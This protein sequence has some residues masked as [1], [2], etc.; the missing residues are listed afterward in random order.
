[1]ICH[2]HPAVADDGIGAVRTIC[3]LASADLLDS[4]VAQAIRLDPETQ[5]EFTLADSLLAAPLTQLGERFEY[6]GYVEPA[7]LF[8]R[9]ATA[10]SYVRLADS[11]AQR[12][13]RLYDDALRLF[14]AGSYVRAEVSCKQALNV[15][16]SI[17]SPRVLDA[18]I[19][20][21]S[22]L[23]GEARG[24]ESQKYY[25]LAIDYCDEHYGPDS[26]QMGRALGGIANGYYS[27]GRYADA[28]PL[29]RRIIEIFT[30]TLGANSNAVAAARINLGLVYGDL[31]RFDRATAELEQALD[32]LQH[33]DP[34][35][36]P[37]IANAL[38]NLGILEARQGRPESAIDHLSQA[39]DIQRRV[40]GRSN[41]WTLT[42]ATQ[43]TTIYMRLGELSKAAIY[44]EEA[45]RLIDSTMG[46]HNAYAAYRRLSLAW[47]R[48]AQRRYDES[49]TLCREAV[50]TYEEL[51]GRGNRSTAEALE[52]LARI[53]RHDEQFDSA[54]VIAARAL[55]MRL[56]VL[57]EQILP[58]AER[59]AL[60]HSALTRN[61]LNGLVASV[62][63]AS[64]SDVTANAIDLILT[65]KGC[66][67]DAMLARHQFFSQSFDSIGQRLWR[68]Y[69]SAIRRQ[70]QLFVAG[71]TSPGD[72]AYHAALDSLWSEVTER[73]AALGRHFGQNEALYRVQIV[74]HR[75]LA[76]C[77]PPKTC[78]VEFIDYESQDPAVFMAQQQRYAAVVLTPD[79]RARVYSLGPA[80]E[81]DSLVEAYQ[82]HLKSIA[83]SGRMPGR[84]QKSEYAMIARA[85]Y[86]RL[87]KPIAPIV[88]SYEQVFVAPDGQLNRL[89]F[90]T[91]IEDDGHYL[92]EKYILQ[93]L[94]AGRDLLRLREQVTPGRGLIAIAD[95]DFSAPVANPS[96]ADGG[97]MTQRGGGAH[98]LRGVS[99]CAD[100]SDYDLYP[101]PG[102]R[103]EI[104]QVDSLWRLEYGEPC[105]DREGAAAT[106]EFLKS[107]APGKRAA[108]LA[109]H[110]YF[111][112]TTCQSD[113][114]TDYSTA[115]DQVV[116]L[117]NPLLKSGLF[118][119]GCAVPAE[120]RDTTSHEDGVLTAAEIS[121][122]NLEG[123]QFVVLSACE[124][125]KGELYNG[126]GVYGLR[127]AFHVAGV[128]TVISA[129]WSIA[130]QFTAPMM[131]TI[132]EHSDESL[133]VR[134]RR[135]Q[136]NWINRL[137]AH[138]LSDHPFTWGAFIA[139][140]DWR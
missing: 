134:L 80:E 15:W 49:E 118:L 48:F 83:E 59:D 109:T 128:R 130:D 21:G 88:E 91:L 4:A 139:E 28:E 44:E 111:L 104:A 126:E 96:Y 67:S 136:L 137:R 81:I 29:Y 133:P 45:V 25:N 97:P 41:P 113:Q 8:Y 72:P 73:E 43:I 140:G 122:L 112:P 106:E 7:R 114:P 52:F 19:Q 38:L 115:V 20:L 60:L 26:Y 33:A 119:A 132:Y 127:R 62:T 5:P 76:R 98:V 57:G 16:Q 101:L 50:A 129:L 108:H 37:G 71:P 40:F 103:E 90:G 77:L 75:D 63:E 9:L 53:E 55:T 32:I 34:P 93:Y 85:L 65:A 123:M 11:A 125:G 138:G 17:N 68:A 10:A 39:L 31:R 56:T 70:S 2:G 66:I 94:T 89:S 14:Y 61:A 92:I 117:D 87:W 131:P 13:D 78:L 6:D 47:L 110:A 18:F 107:S 124:T 36:L 86:T 58:G 116:D 1:M 102:T 22:V 54:A 120:Q 84:A 105:V 35:R 23:L 95:P 30:D 51:Y 46:A 74:D 3:Q 24:D 82:R 135:S 99:P 121:S 64:D 69:K 100:M 42:T 27:S 12:A 79:G